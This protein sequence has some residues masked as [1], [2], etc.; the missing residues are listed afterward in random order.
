MATLQ[1]IHFTTTYPFNL[2][3]VVTSS[4]TNQHFQFH[5]PFISKLYLLFP[6]FGEFLPSQETAVS[7]GSELTM[8]KHAR[9]YLHLIS[10]DVTEL[11]HHH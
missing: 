6:F 11:K 9:I 2:S 10:T 1:Y 4:L 3:T 5:C 7:D 8:C